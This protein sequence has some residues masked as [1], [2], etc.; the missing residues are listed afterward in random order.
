MYRL[1][2][3]EYLK[4]LS[5][6]FN[7]SDH[8]NNLRNY[9]IAKD[10]DSEENSELFR[11]YH[12]AEIL[13]V[14]NEIITN[15]FIR[16]FKKLK[17]TNDRG[18]HL[19]KINFYIGG[20]TD[21]ESI[22]KLMDLSTQIGIEANRNSVDFPGNRNLWFR[23]NEDGSNELKLEPLRVKYFIKYYKELTSLPNKLATS[24]ISSIIRNIFIPNILE[25]IG[26]IKNEE[27]LTELYRFYVLA[28]VRNLVIIHN[29]EKLVRKDI[30]DNLKDLFTVPNSI[31]DKSL[32]LK[33][34]KIIEDIKQDFK[35]YPDSVFKER[36]DVWQKGMVFFK[37]LRSSN[38][39]EI[40][41]N[42][43]IEL[44]HKRLR[45][46]VNGQN[47]IIESLAFLNESS[48]KNFENALSC[49]TIF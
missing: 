27:L 49:Q 15:I 34:S 41:L 5:V 38:D 3:D 2:L 18:I 44:S 39:Y 48:L 22:I 12:R 36:G 23:H 37:T 24:T 17:N 28:G 40:D 1:F 32:Q 31:I 47:Q 35:D 9:L 21:I 4:T 11:N 10:S 25:E 19:A 43:K 42:K 8:F 29:D 6:A 13:K 20:L 26:V 14:N 7:G 45:V 30:N 16:D 46:L 33:M